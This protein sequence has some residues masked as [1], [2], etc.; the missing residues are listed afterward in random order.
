LESYWKKIEKGYNMS[1]STDNYKDNVV[2]PLFSKYIR[3]RDCW[4]TKKSFEYGVCCSCGKTFAYR[5]LEAGHFLPGRNNAYLFYEK[6]VHAQCTNCNCYL[7]GNRVGYERFLIHK[8]G[9]EEVEFQKAL[10]WKTK[11]FTLQELKDL[12]KEI[13][14]KIKDLTINSSFNNLN[15]ET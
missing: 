8:Y 10:H 12:K 5:D 11:K 14:A 13:I 15:I 7:D 6:G 3:M 4:E 9:T 1:S 2:W